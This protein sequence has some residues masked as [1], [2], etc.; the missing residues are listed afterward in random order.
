MRRLLLGSPWARIQIGTLGR[1]RI[2]FPYMSVTVWTEE[3]LWTYHTETGNEST[4]HHVNPRVH[5]RDLNDVADDE[6]DDAE[7]QRLSSTKPIGS[8]GNQHRHAQEVPPHSL[9]ARKSTNQGTDTHQRDEEGLDNGHK[10]VWLPWSRWFASR[11]SI[12]EVRE[13]Q[14]AGDLSGV[15]AKEEATDGGDYPKEDRLNTTFCAVDA[16]GAGRQSWYIMGGA[17]GTHRLPRP[18][19]CQVSRRL[20][21]VD[22]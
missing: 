10:L 3:E 14:H 11:E 16:D 4:H 13:D 9:S 1:Q 6:H 2:G 22:G 18:M 12:S 8:A 19:M 17:R 20:W 21:V 5:G 15:V 7:R